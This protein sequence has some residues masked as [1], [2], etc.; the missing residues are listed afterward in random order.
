MH[1]CPGLV[2][3][4]SVWPLAAKLGKSGPPGPVCAQKIAGCGEPGTGLP[5]ASRSTQCRAHLQ[6]GMREGS[7]SQLT[8]K[9]GDHASFYEHALHRQGHLDPETLLIPP[10]GMYGP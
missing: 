8:R 9:T 5:H 3:L 6:A 2:A 1:A 10:T 7:L 4:R